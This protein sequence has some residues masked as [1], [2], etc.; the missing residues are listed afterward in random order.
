MEMQF[1]RKRVLLIAIAIVVACAGWLSWCR[2]RHW[3]TDGHAIPVPGFGVC[4]P[5]LVAIR[6]SVIRGCQSVIEHSNG[7]SVRGLR[8][9]CG[10][11]HVRP[12]NSNSV[13]VTFWAGFGFLNRREFFWRRHRDMAVAKFRAIVGWA[14]VVVLVAFPTSWPV[15]T[16]LRED[17]GQH[18]NR[19]LNLELSR[20]EWGYTP[21]IK[22]IIS[23]FQTES[24][25]TMAFGS[26]EWSGFYRCLWFKYEPI[27]PVYAM[28]L[29]GATFL[30]I[31]ELKA[32]CPGKLR[33]SQHHRRNTVPQ[34]AARFLAKAANR[35]E[36]G[37]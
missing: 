8:S 33:Q 28:Q 10:G 32:G 22:P 25:T 19:S 21:T 23:F 2:A 1:G 3:L 37:V 15:G 29:A 34:I 30:G 31:E 5:T 7:R 12:T 27:F 13:G 35:V 20:M 16:W 9:D 36:S 14:I 18:A 17:D 11:N 26:T 24:T 6:A 4:W